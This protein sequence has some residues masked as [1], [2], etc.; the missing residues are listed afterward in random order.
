M[1]RGLYAKVSSP[2]RS[3]DV[4]HPV[5]ALVSVDDLPV[6]IAVFMPNH[7]VPVIQGLL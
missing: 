7:V 6:L 5:R 4:A 3:L 2:F 1:C